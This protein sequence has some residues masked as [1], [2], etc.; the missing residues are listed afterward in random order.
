[1]IVRNPRLR[2]GD[3]LGMLSVIGKSSRT[4]T[5]KNMRWIFKCDCGATT[6]KSAGDARRMRHCGCKT[7]RSGRRTKFGFRMLDVPEYP[8]WRRMLRRCYNK[9][10]FEYK[11]YGGRGI[12]VCDQWLINFKQFFQDMGSRPTPLHCIERL[13]NNGNYEPSNCAWSDRVSQNNNKR[14]NIVIE[15]DGERMTIAEWSRKI[16]VSL[17][18]LHSRHYKGLSPEQI[19]SKKVK[20]IGRWHRKGATDVG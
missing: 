15:L 13:D 14:D 12:R 1:M 8:V 2:L 5:T 6:D 11:N 7:V 3:R 17:K 10:C 4:T 9:N 16:G 18:T 19:L 20:R